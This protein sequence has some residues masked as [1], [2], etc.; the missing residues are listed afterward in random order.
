VRRKGMDLGFW[1]RYFPLP[2]AVY[3]IS[4]YHPPPN[5]NNAK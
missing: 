3:H 5:A 4:L 2:L 1:E